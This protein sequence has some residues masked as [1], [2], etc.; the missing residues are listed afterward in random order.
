MMQFYQS[1][2]DIKHLKFKRSKSDLFFSQPKTSS[3]SYIPYLD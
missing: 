3:L 1:L 2:L